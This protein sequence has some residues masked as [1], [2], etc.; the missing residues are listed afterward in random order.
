M[1]NS[2]C[3]CGHCDHDDDE[4][5][6]GSCGDSCGCGHDHGH[7]HQITPEQMEVL[8]KSI[9]EAGYKIE[10]TPDGDIRILEK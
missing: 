3:A 2:P 5:E 4:K 9:L 10:E 8:K 6:E 1:T 7:Q